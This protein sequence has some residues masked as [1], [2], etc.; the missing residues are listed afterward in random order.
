MYDRSLLLVD[1]NWYVWVVVA[2][3][4]GGVVSGN[5]LKN[6]MWLQKI[7]FIEGLEV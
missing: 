2:Q 4:H 3:L 5:F 7:S 1:G 6:R